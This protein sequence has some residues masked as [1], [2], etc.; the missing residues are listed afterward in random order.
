MIGIQPE[1]KPRG[2]NLLPGL[3]K[4]GRVLILDHPVVVCQEVETV[5]FV[6]LTGS[7][8]RTYGTHVIT[9]MRGT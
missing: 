3:A 5:L 4:Q 8:S 2:S 7:D 9:K 6:S 1:G